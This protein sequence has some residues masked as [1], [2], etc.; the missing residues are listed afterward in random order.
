MSFL[1]QPSRVF[2]SSDD[3]ES[4]NGQSFQMTLNEAITNAVNVELSRATIP[5]TQYPIP[6]YLSKFYY[7][8]NGIPDSVQLTNAR[9]FTTIPDLITQINTDAIAQSKPLVF[10]FNSNTNRVSVTIAGTAGQPI[11][12]LSREFYDLAPGNQNLLKNRFGLNTRLGFPYTGL[13][14]LT[15]G[16]TYTG[17]FLPN[18]IRTHVIY[19]LAN[20]AFNDSISTDGLRNVIAKIPVNSAYGG[21]TIFSPP[22]LNYSKIVPTTLQNIQISL[23][24]DNYQAYN[25][26]VEEPTELEIFF[27]YATL[28]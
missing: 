15:A 2:I 10:T 13:T 24:D 12:I 21:I 5:N 4:G 22:E 19:V 16:G 17:T 8:L 18:I 7:S 11:A 1:N 25:L 27:K 26:V 23:L 3:L 14:G 20:F 9:N 6:N 28:N